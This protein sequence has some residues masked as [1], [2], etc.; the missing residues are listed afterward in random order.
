MSLSG[1]LQIISSAV[2]S[3]A[4]LIYSFFAIFKTRQLINFNLSMMKRRGTSTRASRS[5][6]RKIEN[7]GSYVNMR[8][9]AVGGLLMALLF[10]FFIIK[11]LIN[12]SP[13]N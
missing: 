9:A 6:E 5:Y 8:I 3:I 13:I 12:H 4:L 7:K 2:I 11:G 1:I 10:L